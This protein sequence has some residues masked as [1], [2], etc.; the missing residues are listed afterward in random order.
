MKRTAKIVTVVLALL[1]AGTALAS[2]ASSNIA[3]SAS[4]QAQ[5]E[6]EAD[7]NFGLD[8]VLR[9]LG[10]VDAEA[11]AAAESSG[12]AEAEGNSSGEAFL[13]E[14]FVSD[15]EIQAQ[16]EAEA[17]ERVQAETPRA[18]A[19]PPQVELHSHA[20]EV[21]KMTALADQTVVINYDAGVTSTLRDTTS[22]AVEGPGFSGTLDLVGAADATGQAEG[23]IKASTH[24]AVVIMEKG[25]TLI[26]RTEGTYDKAYQLS[27]DVYSEVRE[28]A[29]VEVD[30]TVRAY[31]SMKAQAE[32]EVESKTEW[33]VRQAEFHKNV[34]LDLA[35]QVQA[36]ADA[37]AST[38]ARSAS[39]TSGSA[40]GH[41]EGSAEAAASAAG[42][43]D[44]DAHPPV[45]EI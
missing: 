27:A 33:A 17:E 38:A 28:E 8:T 7:A 43:G 3:G 11:D 18:P 42:S 40:S 45:C 44:G 19:F 12:D 16:A 29:H 26:M 30:E 22:A 34:V 14:S 4:G 23:E 25:E 39:Q 32:A 31:L 10:F 36:T 2:A 21:F 5:A 20:K 15:I 41:A 35:G 37:A 9:I 1:L 13:D 6:A 24:Q